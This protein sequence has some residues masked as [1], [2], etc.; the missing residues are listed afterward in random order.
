MNQKHPYQQL[1]PELIIDAVESTG[2]L[3]DMRIFPLNSYE[4]RVYQIG[5]DEGEPLI[6]KCQR[7]HS[8]N[9]RLTR[10]AENGLRRYPAGQYRQ[11]SSHPDHAVASRPKHR[12]LG[13]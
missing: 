4:N 11:P 9:Y 2:R 3:S 1:T 8:L 6:A 7:R 5:M 12:N 13:F 10:P